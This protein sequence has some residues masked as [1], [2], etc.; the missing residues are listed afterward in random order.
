[1]AGARLH[2]RPPA[3]GALRVVD[4]AARRPRPPRP[5]TARGVRLAPA[6]AAAGAVGE[7]L[8]R[9]LV[10]DEHV[11]DLGAQRRDDRV[12]LARPAGHRHHALRPAHLVEGDAEQPVVE[13]GAHR[14]AVDVEEA[15]RDVAH[16]AGRGQ[17]GAQRRRHRLGVGEHRVGLQR[18]DAHVHR[19]EGV[20][21]PQ[22]L[23]QVRLVAQRVAHAPRGDD[24]GRRQRHRRGAE[25]PREP[26]HHV[27][28]VLLVLR[29]PDAA[30]RLHD[31]HVGGRER[32]HGVDHGVERGAPREADGLA[33]LQRAGEVRGGG[34]A[35]LAAEEVGR[36]PRLDGHHEGLAEAEAILELRLEFGV[37]PARRR[38]GDLDDALRLRLGEQPGDG[39][40]RDAQPVGDLLLR[41]V[42][43]VV[44]R[45][46]LAEQVQVRGGP[47]PGHGGTRGGG[48]AASRGLTAA[49]PGRCYAT[50]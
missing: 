12:D 7:R 41:L 48:A 16:R 20:E 50:R 2:A 11:E 38:D 42:A 18:P 31:A 3:R 34:G 39:G 44:E 1:V 8:G 29:P 30:E 25:E 14:R 40:A 35:E 23:L 36:L 47:G 21:L 15:Q 46:N 22:R 49:V 17:L 33:R 37:Q 19:V 27:G 10:G 26:A 4:A 13:R 5:A 9:E 28:G 32:G 45:A 43:Q 24:A 6:P